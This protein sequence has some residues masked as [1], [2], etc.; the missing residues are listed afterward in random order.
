MVSQRL[1][2][3]SDMGSALRTVLA[4]IQPVLALGSN[5]P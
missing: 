4:G 3:N 1:A 5:I 2:I